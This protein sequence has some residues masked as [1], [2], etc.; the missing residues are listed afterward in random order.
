MKTLTSNM[1][2]YIGGRVGWYLREGRYRP[3]KIALKIS[4]LFDAY[5]LFQ[6]ETIANHVVVVGMAGSL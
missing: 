3:S 2:S 5:T 6:E 4:F 1:H